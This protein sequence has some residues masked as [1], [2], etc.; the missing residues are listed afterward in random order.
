[1]N[2][3]LILAAVLGVLGVVVGIGYGVHRA[4]CDAIAPVPLSQPVTLEVAEGASSRLIAARLKQEG[5]VRSAL[6]FRI[7][8]A[9]YGLEKRLKPGVYSFS[10]SIAIEGVL[11]NLRRGRVAFVKVTVPE[12]Y[13]CKMAAQ[14]F[15]SAGA[16]SAAAL[17]LALA[18]PARLQRVFPDWENLAVP[19]GLIFP[20]T[21]TIDR[22]MSPDRLADL[23]LET[24]RTRY[25]AIL[26]TASGTAATLSPY[27]RCILA[28]IIEKEARHP[29]D[30]P[31]V[32]SVFYNRLARGMRLESCATV[33][34]ALPRDT[35][36]LTFADLTLESPYN[37]YKNAGLPPSP[38]AN[39]G[40]DALRAANAPATTDYLFFVADGQG[41][42]RFS[43]T[44]AEHDRAAKDYFQQ[45]R[46]N[47]SR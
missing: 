43:R 9:W 2:R 35:D 28:S 31:L 10:G 17:L 12:G 3:R 29:E 19:E 5:V 6:L 46:Q 20:D 16:A 37:T 42:H 33:I 30:R 18:N 40:I 23:L 7:M 34:Y 39:F 22:Q 11:E 27:Q 21:Y 45:R 32:A 41:G 13:T 14:R 36:R 26:A 47:N 4:Y 15:E 25:G 38:I 44:K 8:V 24:A 1:M